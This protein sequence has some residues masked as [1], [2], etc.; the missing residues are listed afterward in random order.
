M[1]SEILRMFV[2]YSL[3]VNLCTIDGAIKFAP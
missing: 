2:G 1:F 3:I